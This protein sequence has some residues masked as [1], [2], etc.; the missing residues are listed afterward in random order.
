MEGKQYH[1]LQKKIKKVFVEKFKK[2]DNGRIFLIR[3]AVYHVRLL[4]F[5]LVKVGHVEKQ[6]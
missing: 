4:I 1:V 5:Q 6:I 3:I 2:I